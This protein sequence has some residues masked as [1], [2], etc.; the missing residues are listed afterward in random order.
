MGKEEKRTKLMKLEN[1]K[2][3][4]LQKSVGEDSEEDLKLE[5]SKLTNDV[6]QI[7]TDMQNLT[8]DWSKYRDT[9]KY[10]QFLTRINEAMDHLDLPE[11]VKNQLNRLKSH[12]SA[13]GAS[14]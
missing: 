14:D 5:K 10:E 7:E 8:N 1:L 4:M 9:K 3:K 2:I 12:F 13:H 6:T 11:D